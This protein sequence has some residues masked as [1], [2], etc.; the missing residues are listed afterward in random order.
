MSMAASGPTAGRCD[1]RKFRVTEA[2]PFLNIP[3]EEIEMLSL[4]PAATLFNIAPARQF[5]IR[6]QR[7]WSLGKGRIW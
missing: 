5:G 3:L 2:Y 7:Q 1:W 6:E 4:D